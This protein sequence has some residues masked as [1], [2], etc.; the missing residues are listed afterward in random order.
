MMDQVTKQEERRGVLYMIICAVLWSTAGIF[1]KLIPWSSFAIAGWRSLFSAGCLFL[2]MKTA[3]IKI[4]VSRISLSNAVFM[5]L[6]FFGF[7][8][9]NK[10]TTAANAI[11]LQY[12][13]PIWILI[14]SA[15]VYKQRF[16]RVDIIATG[17]TLAGILLFFFDQ[18]APGNMTGNLIALASGFFMACMFTLNGHCSDE[19]RMSGILF[20][21]LLTALV[22]I[23]YSLFEGTEFTLVPVMCIIFLGV[24]QLG[25]P[26]VLYGIANR[27][28]PPLTCSLVGTVE[29]LLNPVWVL[30]FDGERPGPFALA[31]SCVVILSITLWMLVKDKMA[32]AA[33]EHRS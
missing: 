16:S 8:T 19:E 3:K 13:G 6:L 17:C 28:C 30:I 4:T 9:A 2:Y 14:L 18:L 24:V 23:P 15:V 20:G 29:P 32:K 12:T 1:I 5:A 25:I 11:M 10:L 33:A 21:H 26:Y 22:G 27:S 31:G 7:V